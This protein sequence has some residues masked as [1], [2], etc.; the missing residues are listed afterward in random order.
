M[1]AA[2]FQESMATLELPAIGYGIRYEFGI[3]RQQIGPTG[4]KESTDPW[5]ALGNPWEVIRS[6]PNASGRWS[7]CLCKRGV[8]FQLREPGR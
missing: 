3:F 1:R 2:C 8:W 6:T 7:R 4:Q 5:L